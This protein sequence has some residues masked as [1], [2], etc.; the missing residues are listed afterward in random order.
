MP[1]LLSIIQARKCRQGL[2][3][4]FLSTRKKSIIFF[5]DFWSILDRFWI[6]FDR[7]RIDIWLTFTRIDGGKS[8][9]DDLEDE[10]VLFFVL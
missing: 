5:V 9:K 6:D 7:F 10:S 1:G 4:I 2:S 3:A 8:I